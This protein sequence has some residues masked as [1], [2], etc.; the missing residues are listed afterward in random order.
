MKLS[1]IKGKFNKEH[2]DYEIRILIRNSQKRKE[3]PAQGNLAIVLKKLGLSDKSYYWDLKKAIWR[4]LNIRNPIKFPKREIKTIWE[5]EINNAAEITILREKEGN[6]LLAR[7][8]LPK[9]PDKDKLDEQFFEEIIGTKIKHTNKNIISSALASKY[10][11]PRRSKKIAERFD[12]GKVLHNKYCVISVMGPHAG[13]N[14][15]KI[16][17]RKIDDIKMAGITFWLIKSHKAKPDLVQTIC[18]QAI[19][20]REKIYC[21]FIEPSS[22]GGSIP[23]K[24]SDSAKLFSSDKLSWSELPKGISPVTGKIANNAYGLVFNELTLV[25]GEIDLWDYA[26]YFNSRKPLKIIQGASTLCAIKN[27]MSEISPN[28]KIKS[29]FRQIIAVGKLCTPYGVWLK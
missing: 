17:S 4:L 7:L 25:N 8:N 13:E 5:K 29:R 9:N 1:E 16:F 20:N 19:K 10:K 14:E 22:A 28:E 26:E 2:N 21:I 27:N 3:Q 18:F 24:F 15:G 12:L 11:N 23:T 6:K